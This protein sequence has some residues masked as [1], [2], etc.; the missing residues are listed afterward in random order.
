MKHLALVILAAAPAFA[1]IVS[2]GIKAGSPVGGAVPNNPEFSLK[3]LQHSY[4]LGATAEIHFPLRLSVEVD[5]IYKRT[6][7]ST[8][9]GYLSYSF[10]N[11]VT[12]NQWEFPVLAKYEITGERLRPFVDAGPVL[13]HISGITDF[14]TSTYTTPY[15]IFPVSYTS[16]TTSN[17]SPYLQNR[18]SPGFVV[19]AGV[20]LKAFHV[21]ISPEYRYTRWGTAAF[22]SSGLGL[23]ISNPNQQD[24]M[25]G[26]AF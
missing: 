13:R 16:S 6:G 22:G 12:A 26:F 21:R 25:V 11:R 1:Q 8:D 3:S 5:A 2:V 24:L 17:N 18:N 20:T 9:S 23:T 19:G 10:S 15:P 7:F 14:F 4:L